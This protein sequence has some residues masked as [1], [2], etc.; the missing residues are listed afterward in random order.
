MTLNETRRSSVRM[1]VAVLDLVP[2]GV[3]VDFDEGTHGIRLCFQGHTQERTKEIRSWFHGVVW[4]KAYE[5]SLK[6]WTYTTVF[7]GVDINIYAVSEA[8]PTCRGAPR[9]GEQPSSKGARWECFPGR[10][11]ARCPARSSWRAGTPGWTR[12]CASWRYRAST[13]PAAGSWGPSGAVRCGRRKCAPWP[14]TF[15]RPAG[16]RRRLRRTRTYPEPASG[17]RSS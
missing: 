2:D 5:E 6:W 17:P 15:P 10:C 4:T 14:G 8:P 13:A 1:L 7:Q 11:T 12:P 16:H 9:L 3:W